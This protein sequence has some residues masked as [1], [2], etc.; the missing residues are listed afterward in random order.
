MDMTTFFEMIA[1]Y[2]FPIVLA[3]FLVYMFVKDHFDVLKNVTDKLETIQA[4]MKEMQNDYN[5]KLLELQ[6]NINTTLKLL[7]DKFKEN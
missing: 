6:A 7:T 3:G 4:Q 1:Q 2:G 5:S